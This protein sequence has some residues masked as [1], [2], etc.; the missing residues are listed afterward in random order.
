[1]RYGLIL[2]ALLATPAGA[3]PVAHMTLEAGTV[4][5]E[6]ALDKAPVTVCNF[7]RYAQGGH[8]DGGVFFRTVLSDQS[9]RG[10]DVIQA[11]VAAGHDE[12]K[13]PPIALERTSRTGLSHGVGTISMARDGADTAT[14]S[15]FVV[16]KDSRNLD[17]GG[18]R[19]ADGQG[20]AAFGHVIR[21]MDILEAIQKRPAQ[22]EQI[23]NP[24]RILR[25]R[26]TGYDAAARAACTAP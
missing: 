9:P 11:R 26:L 15:F 24:A 2:A 22:K 18:A 19:N 1:M 21:G 20:F 13:F 4:D 16:L 25:L 3:N 23:T 7:I 17:F 5:V 8:Y 14:S 12:D 10:I 6:L